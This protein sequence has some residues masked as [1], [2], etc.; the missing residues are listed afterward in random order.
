MIKLSISNKSI[1]ETPEL[2][3]WLKNCSNII[4]DELKKITNDEI[5]RMKSKFMI[6][7]ATSISSPKR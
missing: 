1:T 6:F 3:E 2:T 7:G 5:E 4:N